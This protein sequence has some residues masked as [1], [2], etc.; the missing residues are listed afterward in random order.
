MPETGPDFEAGLKTPDFVAI[1][2][3][4][5]I[6]FGIA[7][8]FGRRQKSTEDFFVGGGESPGLRSV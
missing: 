1:A 5:L 4:L 7:L 6:T 3:Y 8:W 2:F